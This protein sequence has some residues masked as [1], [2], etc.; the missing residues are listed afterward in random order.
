MDAK[1]IEIAIVGSGCRFPGDATTPSKLWD[2]LKAPRKV[3]KTA[4]FLEGYQHSNAKYH[5]HANVKD[6][7]LLNDDASKRQFDASFFGVNPLEAHAMDPQIRMTLETIYEALEDGGHSLESLKGSDTA[8]Y[9]GQMVAD[10]EL[11]MHRDHETMATYHITG[12]ARTMLSS[13][14]SFFYDWTGPSMTIDTA[15]SSSLSALH[16]AVQQLRTGH[17]RVAVVT[18]ANLIFDVGT[19]I[20]MSNFTML[21][22]DSECRMWDA[23]ANGYARG[24]GVAAIILKTREA[25][26]AD[27]DHI[28]CI[29]RE[30]ALNQ[31]GRSLG[32]TMQVHPVLVHFYVFF[33]LTLPLIA[34]SLVLHMT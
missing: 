32:P 5:G 15:C 7:Y 13:R 27:G 4:D 31:D 3:S 23:S 18:A 12:T 6:A 26:E 2:L 20:A 8:V 16:H 10:Y 17:S 1:P 30:T 14:V 24:D 19:F 21:S 33:G 11:L 28:E 25:A 22:P 34:L 9:A 29:I